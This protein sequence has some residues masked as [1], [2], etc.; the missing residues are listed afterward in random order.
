MAPELKAALEEHFIWENRVFALGQSAGEY[1]ASWAQPGN[2]KVLYIPSASQL[3]PREHELMQQLYHTQDYITDYRE[4]HHTYLGTDPVAQILGSEN[5][6]SS[7]D[8]KALLNVQDPRVQVCRFG[9]GVIVNDDTLIEIS[10]FRRRNPSTAAYTQLISRMRS[11]IKTFD[12]KTSSG[13]RTAPGSSLP[14]ILRQYQFHEVG[15]LMDDVRMGYLRRYDYWS[16]SI[17][18]GRIVRGQ[19]H[20]QTYPILRGTDGRRSVVVD[21]HA[22]TEPTAGGL[23]RRDVITARALTPEELERF[24]KKRQ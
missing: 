3:M 17:F 4:Q 12:G 24:S 23:G 2:S 10:D 11:I 7:E 1:I 19:L 14:N 20:G 18:F 22:F 8:F 15:N 9:A 21:G 16:K 6:D 5:R 13:W